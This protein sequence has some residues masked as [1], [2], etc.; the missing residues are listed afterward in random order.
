MS[1]AYNEKKKF[2]SIG[3]N[4]YELISE[5]SRGKTQMCQNKMEAQRATIKYLV[6]KN[7]CS[8]VKRKPVKTCYRVCIKR[9]KTVQYV[10][11]IFPL[12]WF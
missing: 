11:S 7:T 9:E 2:H 12:S 8:H 5:T 1:S 3:S 10:I 6:Q 4:D